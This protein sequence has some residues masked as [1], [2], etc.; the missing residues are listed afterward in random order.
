MRIMITVV[1]ALALVGCA[2]LGDP[3]RAEQMCK[4]YDDRAALAFQDVQRIRDSLDV[5]DIDEAE[6]A[7]R[8]LELDR[9]TEVLLTMERLA[10]I[11]CVPVVP[12]APVIDGGS[13]T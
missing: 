10:D 9:A 4:R 11:W 8:A 2:T 13:G 6:R 12:E 1:G 3:E 5:L 7:L